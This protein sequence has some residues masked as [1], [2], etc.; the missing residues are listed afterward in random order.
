VSQPYTDWELIESKKFESYQYM[1]FNVTTE[2]K[3]IMKA[4]VYAL[5]GTI[6]QEG[7]DLQNLRAACQNHG[8]QLG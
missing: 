3:T 7:T 8:R 1:I 6:W 4:W 5:N 2:G